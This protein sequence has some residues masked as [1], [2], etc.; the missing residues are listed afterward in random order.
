MKISIAVDATPIISALIGGVSRDILF[1][2]RFNF[3]S[4]EFTINEVKKYIPIIS[5]KSEVSKK[6]KH[7]TY[8]LLR[9]IL[10]QTI[11]IK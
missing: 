9:F 5:K 2:H 8:Y 11:K 7:Y 6:E 3:I 10:N 1:D 4:T